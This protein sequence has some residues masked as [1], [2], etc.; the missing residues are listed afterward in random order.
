VPTAVN[1]ARGAVR[2]TDQ[3]GCKAVAIIFDSDPCPSFHL[4]VEG[5]LAVARA[6]GAN[7]PVPHVGMQFN[8]AAF[9]ACLS[10]SYS[11]KYSGLSN[12]LRGCK[13]RHGYQRVTAARAGHRGGP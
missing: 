9:L 10:V 1:P 4:I 12:R 11:S 7:R 5:D 6:P 13:S 3:D 8:S 2:A